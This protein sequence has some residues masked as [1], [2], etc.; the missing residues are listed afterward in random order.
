M[1]E[2]EMIG[3]RMAAVRQRVEQEQAAARRRRLVADARRPA[4]EPRATVR[5][6]AGTALARLG[7]L[8]GGPAAVRAAMRSAR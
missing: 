3:D 1:M 7:L 4:G 8:L 2:Y 5:L 6:A